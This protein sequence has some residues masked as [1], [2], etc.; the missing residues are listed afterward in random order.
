M[1]N[2]FRFFLAGTLI[3]LTVVT[4]LITSFEIIPSAAACDIV[5]EFCD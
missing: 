4:L 3:V 2:I 1:I 5:I